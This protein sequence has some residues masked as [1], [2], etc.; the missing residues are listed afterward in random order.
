MNKTADLH[1]HTH[2]SDGTF[3]PEKVVEY[4]KASGLSA[5]A[6]TDHDCCC[7]ITP[8]ILAAKDLDVEIIPGVELTA[9]VDD[10]EIHILG[11]FIDWQDD[12]FARKLKEISKVREERAKEILKR[13]RKHGV[14]IS[15]D[16]LFEL[17]GPGSVGRLHIAQLLYKK[18]CTSSIG[19]A[20]TKY[21]GN[22]GSCYVKKFKLT[23]EEAVD[24]IR[25][26][27]G[28]SV[29]AHPKTIAIQN[30][31]IEDV[32][33]L[34]AKNGVRGIEVYHSDHSLKNEKAFKA[35]AEKYNLLIT[36]GSDCHGFG[37]REVLIGKVK[38]PYELVENLKKA[39]TN[40]AVFVNLDY[41]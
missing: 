22:G 20:F 16:E 28:I 17:S 8:A 23:P 32:V 4:A 14:D 3:T 26:V 15:D 13:L 21:I 10:T 12:W 31:S 6:I 2:L 37:K 35:L 18:R 29:M 25:R 11:Y 1:V 33:A 7:A 39:L 41:E 24:M 19:Q 30:K 27:G 34:L 9:E 38:I 36:G 40:N 5:I